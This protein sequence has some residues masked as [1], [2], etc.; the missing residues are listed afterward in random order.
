MLRKLA[1]ACGT[2]LI[3]IFVMWVVVNAAVGMAAPDITS[4]TWLNSD[5]IHPGDLKG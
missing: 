3:V 1:T 4:Q 5:P 2:I